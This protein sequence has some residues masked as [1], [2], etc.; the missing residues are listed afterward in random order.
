MKVCEVREH[1]Q[2]LIIEQTN[3]KETPGDLFIR[4]GKLL[5]K[6]KIFNFITHVDLGIL[7]NGHY[8]LTIE[9]MKHSIPPE[10]C[11]MLDEKK[12]K[13]TTKVMD[14]MNM[15]EKRQYQEFRKLHKDHHT[16]IRK[17]QTGIG[18]KI[19]IKCDCGAEK[20]ITDY[21]TW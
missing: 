6:L 17:I 5:N 12:A 3:S 13:Q 10:D 19:V 21:D 7:S 15:C 1:I 11:K 20:D 16:R 9:V 14:K 8:L 4:A 2:R 18:I